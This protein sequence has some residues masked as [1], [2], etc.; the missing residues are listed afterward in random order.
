VAPKAEQQLTLVAELGDLQA[1]LFPNVALLNEAHEGAGAEQEEGV[2]LDEVRLA[3]D[4]AARP[5]R[6]A[7]GAVPRPPA[8]HSRNEGDRKSVV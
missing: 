3:A 7:E 4:A 1:E 2:D 5:R 6:R 8:K